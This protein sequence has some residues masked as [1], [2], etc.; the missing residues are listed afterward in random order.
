M[1]SISSVASSVSSSV[2]SSVDQQALAALQFQ[3]S[4]YSQEANSQ[5]SQAKAA[6]QSLQLALTSGNVSQAQSAVAQLQQA[7]Q[8]AN[9]TA[10]A[11][12]LPVTTDPSGKDV[13]DA[14]A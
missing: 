7:S 9:A 1:S 6:Y 14:R 11:S 10:P 13:L 4:V 2:V 3:L 5:N 12:I 8:S